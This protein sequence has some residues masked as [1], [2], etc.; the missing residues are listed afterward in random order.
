MSTRPNIRPMSVITNGTMAG[1]ITSSPT[2][3]SNTTVASYALSWTGSTPIGT[4]AVQASNDYSLYA[5]GTV[6]NPGTWSTLTLDYGGS[7][8]QS[9]PITGNTGTAFIDMQQI[10]AYAIRLV[11]TATSGTGT[12]QCTVVAKAA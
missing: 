6:D 3:I 11:Y 8:V 5:N 1:N 9:I 7:A 4:A 2:I 12:L 10:G